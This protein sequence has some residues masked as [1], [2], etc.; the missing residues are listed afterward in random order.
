[1]K[2]KVRGG[3]EVPGAK[4]RELYQLSTAI[5]SNDLKWKT[6]DLLVVETCGGKI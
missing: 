5:Y 6:K 2:L 4:G 1:M 3:H